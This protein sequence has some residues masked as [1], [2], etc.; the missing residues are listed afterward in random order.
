M[1]KVKFLQARKEYPTKKIEAHDIECD[2][3]AL[4]RKRDMLM[5]LE[6][7]VADLKTELKAQT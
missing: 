4:K 5:K 2:T 7:E 6:E 3:E 1:K